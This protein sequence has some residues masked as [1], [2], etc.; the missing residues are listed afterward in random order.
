[1]STKKRYP[2]LISF[3]NEFTE[4]LLLNSIGKHRVRS[5]EK[6]RFI[7]EGRPYV[8]VKPHLGYHQSIAT[9]KPM[10]PHHPIKH[11]VKHPPHQMRLRPGIAALQLRSQP[12]IQEKVP[13]T[14]PTDVIHPDLTKPLPPGFNL[15]K[16]NHLVSDP[17][18]TMIECPGPGKYVLV[19]SRL[20][21]SITNISLGESEVRDTINIFSQAARI[22]LI[23]GVFKAAVGNLVIIAILSD[24]VGSKFI[25]T[26]ASPYS[27]L[28][29]VYN[30]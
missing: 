29:Q 10:M 6:R 26:K 1:M 18:V 21:S 9:R 25:I 24:F 27:I 7:V 23:G 11:T 20:K 13:T 28:E 2:A 3:L 8:P 14:T 5:F 17:K 4:E 16:L 22:P 19:R 30:N 15:G 12:G